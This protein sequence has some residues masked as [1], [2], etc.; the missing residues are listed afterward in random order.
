MNRLEI[1]FWLCAGIVFY[2]F[3]GYG[4]LLLIWAWLKP[5]FRSAYRLSTE[6]FEPAVTL[7]IPCYNEATALEEKIANCLSLH[8]PAD[9]CKLVFITDGSTDQSVDIIQKYPEIRLLHLPERKGKTAAENRAMQFVQTPVV[10]FSDANALLNPEAI[11][12]MVKH[13]ADERTGCVAGAKKIA[14]PR[15]ANAGTAG[16]G[17]YWHYESWLKQLDSQCNSAV[18]AAGELVAFRTDLYRPLPEDTILDDFMQS[19]QI[20]AE[21]YRVVYEPKACATEKGSANVEEELKRKIRIATGSW[22]AM[23]RLRGILR[24]QKTPVLCF[25]YFSHRI[26]RW[27]VTP[28]LLIVVWLLNMILWVAGKPVYVYFFYGQVLFYLTAW[29]GYLLRNRKLLLQWFFIP[30]YFCV[31]HYAVLAGW[32]QYKTPKNLTGIWEKAVRSDN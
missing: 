27:A 20:A 2:S 24:W 32:V 10:I 29:I 13:F 14:V 3:L 11:R 31:M 7:V 25:Q 1:F 18:G 6:K 9:K 21:G 26:L 15:A 19:M 23:K 4:V 22:Q 5:L 16:E 30:Y 12:E 28:V 17:M 8:Y